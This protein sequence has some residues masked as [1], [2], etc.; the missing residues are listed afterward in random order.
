MQTL[1]PATGASPPGD[2]SGP[3]EARRRR[4]ALH[5]HPQQLVR[6]SEDTLSRRAAA[7]CDGAR[8]E[9]YHRLAAARSAPPSQADG[10]LDVED[11]VGLPRLTWYAAAHRHHPRDS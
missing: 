1:K 11:A 2:L 9:T 10:L 4:Q 8:A 6:L 5:F 3:R 7:A